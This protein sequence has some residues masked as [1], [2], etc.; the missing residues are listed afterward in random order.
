MAL[1]EVKFSANAGEEDLA[2]LDER[3]SIITWTL[4]SR[5]VNPKLKYPISTITRLIQLSW[6]N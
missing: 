4:R 3:L 2:R 1:H 6:A 5:K